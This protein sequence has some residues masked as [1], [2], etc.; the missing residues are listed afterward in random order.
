[1]RRCAS[2][3]RRFAQPRS[4]PVSGPTDALSIT[5]SSRPKRVGDGVDHRRA[6]GFVGDV[7]AQRRR[8]PA[9][10][11]DGLSNGFGALCPLAVVHDDV[12]VGAG[13][14]L[15]DLGADASRTA[16]DQDDPCRCVVHVEFLPSLPC[17]RYEAPTVHEF[18][19]KIR[20]T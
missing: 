1:M 7:G 5:A 18:L 14:L 8:V 10:A 4:A 12:G 9:C 19:R 11:A 3:L 17:F 2:R 15:R 6:L 13:E 16:G 20:H